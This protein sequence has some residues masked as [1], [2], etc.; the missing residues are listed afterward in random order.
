[1]ALE[2]YRPYGN[3]SGKSGVASYAIG[4][5]FIVVR[6]KDGSTY[7][8]DYPSTGKGLVDGLVNRARAGYGLNRFIN[9]SVGSAY[10]E[11]W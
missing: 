2:G 11:K 8:Y 9:K 1:M 3:L 4:E 10:A 6:F 5:G 7:K